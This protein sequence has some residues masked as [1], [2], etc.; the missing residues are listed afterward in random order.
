M[1]DCDWVI[2]VV[3]RANTWLHFKW[4]NGA[5]LVNKKFMYKLNLFNWRTTFKP[6]S[7]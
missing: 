5:D 7:K 6:T 1:K 4:S 2:E 3:V